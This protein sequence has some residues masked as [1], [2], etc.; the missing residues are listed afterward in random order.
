VLLSEVPIPKEQV[1]AI[2]DT[3]YSNNKDAAK[4]AAEAY[5]KR[6]K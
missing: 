4:P 3:L 6:L 5:D 2:D 1:H